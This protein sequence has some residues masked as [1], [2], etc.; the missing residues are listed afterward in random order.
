MTRHKADGL[1]VELSHQ[2]EQEAHVRR[3]KTL[4]LCLLPL[5]LFAAGAVVA[6]ASGERDVALISFDPITERLSAT[7]MCTLDVVYDGAL[8]SSG[9]KGYSLEITFDDTY[10]YVDSLDIHVTEG[11]FLSDVGGTAF[12]VLPVDENTFTVDCAILGATAGAVGVGDLCSI[13]FKGRTGDGTSVVE[14]ID[15]RLR[16]PDNQ[17]IVSSDAFAVLILDNTPPDIPVIDPEP[18][19]TPGTTNFITWSDMS[20]FGAVGYCVQASMTPTFDVIVS[21]SGC[22]P[23]NYH[24]FIGLIDGQIYYYRVQCRD[25]LWN[26]SDWSDYEESTQDDT[27]P[28]TEAGPIDAYYNVVSF[29]VPFTATDATSGVQYV[30]L[31]YQRDGGGYVQYGSTFTTSP[32]AFV[33]PGDGF[34]EFYTRGTDNVDNVE[35]AP[36]TPD[37]TTEV[38]MTPPL[39]PVDLVALPGHNKISLSWNVPVSR[40]APIEGTVLIRRPWGF[41]AY[42]EYD[43]WGAPYGYPTNPS[44]G[45]VIAFVPGTGP[46]TYEDT[47]FNDN[48]RNVHY[49]SAFTR[50]SAGNY[51]LAASSAQDRST[52]YWL[53]DVREPT[54]TPRT[55][56]GVVDY[57]D[58]VAYSY[59]YYAVHGDPTY[60]NEL[61]VGPT[62]DNSRMGIPLTDNAINFEDLMILAMNYGRVSPTI[63]GDTDVV[64]WVPSGRALLALEWEQR[65]LAIGDEVEINLTLNDTESLARGVSSL[66]TFEPSALEFLSAAQ[67]ALSDGSVESFFFSMEEETGRLRVDFAALGAEA[68]M[69]ASCVVAVLRF[70]VSSTEPSAM[71]I[72]DAILR[73]LRNHDFDCAVSGLRFGDGEETPLTLRLRQNVPNPF[74]PRTTIAFDL[75]DRSAVTLRVYGV[76]GREVATL[77]DEP[78]DAGTHVVP[79][80]GTDQRGG[81]AASG[82]YFYVLDAEGLRLTQKMVLMR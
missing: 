63:R 28:D 23:Y 54:G 50:D 30:E 75:P 4:W 76:D 44:D 34:Y 52:S 64:G 12:Y 58:K 43:D 68:A 47:T 80:D 53:A 46:Q 8:V 2:E 15:V 79:W 11:S 60:D 33:A 73:D 40:D 39:A 69:P 20:P 26:V 16:D 48:M 17:E 6:N 38:D 57:Y 66:I 31:Y 51:S 61:D 49:Y 18:E 42:P 25:D 81:D 71:D 19:F 7:H 65:E 5:L 74:N 22:T 14:F 67:G 72:D 32:I 59:S 27:P 10:V 45:F 56:D 21:T 35:D 41:W 37:C 9:L 36:V 62:D 1:A 55:Y 77:V 24:N 29:N 70:R 3:A 78:R 13:T 82:V